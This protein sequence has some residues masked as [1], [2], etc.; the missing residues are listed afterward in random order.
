ADRAVL[1]ATERAF[2]TVGDLIGRN[3]MRQAINEAMRSVAE[4]NKYV[5]DSEP[6]KLK[7]EADR[8]R[9]ATILHVMAQC[10]SDLNVLLSPFLPFS[11]N[12]IDAIL[13]G[14][15]QVQPLPDLV[16]AEDLD[17][18]AGYPIIT[19]DY[20]STR[21]WGRAIPGPAARPT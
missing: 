9:L 7:D 2:G 17:G 13:G 4:V 18:G 6:W 8:D 5:T 16:E 21:P 12:A 11:A 1:D 19:G 14:D 15:G 10:V 20:S 3:R